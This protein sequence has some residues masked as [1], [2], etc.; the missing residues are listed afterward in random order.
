MG[1]A[2]GCRGVDGDFY[3]VS[4]RLPPRFEHPARFQG[5][6][7]KEPHPLYRTSNQSYGSRAPTVHEMPTC[8]RI[9]SHAFSSTLAPCGMY[10]DNGLNTH[11][12]KSRVT[13][14][15]N[16]ITACDRLNFHPSY[17]PSRPSFC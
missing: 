7:K 1:N 14:A 9:T 15:G 17:N 8:Y 16:F 5:Y 2:M 10:R 6:R 4:E 12:D 3:G 13:G 11:L